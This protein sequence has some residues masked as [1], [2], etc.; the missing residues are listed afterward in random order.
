MCLCG[1]PSDCRLKPGAQAEPSSVPQLGERERKRSPLPLDKKNLAT[2][3]AVEE[4]PELEICNPQTQTC[5][6]ACEQGP[7]RPWPPPPPDTENRIRK[8]AGLG[9]DETR[10][11]GVSLAPNQTASC[12]E[13]TGSLGA[14]SP[15]ALLPLGSVFNI[16]K[17]ATR[18]AKVNS[19][20]GS[21][22]VSAP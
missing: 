5:Q 8:T 11:P 9:L 13:G 20:P 16:C 10:G 4:V 1:E 7:D 19:V 2:R 14:D 12:R 22:K 6:E 21:S 18:T 17:T 3:S 15:R